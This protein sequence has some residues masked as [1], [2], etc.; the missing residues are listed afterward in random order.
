MP[1]LRDFK[2]PRENHIPLAC[3]FEADH[4]RE[5]RAKNL[6]GARRCR[7]A[8]INPVTMLIP[9]LAVDDPRVKAAVGKWIARARSCH[10][11]A[12]GRRPVHQVAVIGGGGMVEGALYASEA[13]DGRAA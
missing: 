13:R 3:L 7:E 6:N 11:L 12:M 2:A 8:L 5:M 4:W 1:R 10:E 9:A